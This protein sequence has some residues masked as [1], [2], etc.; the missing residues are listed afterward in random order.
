MVSIEAFRKLALA[1][2][3]TSEDTH[4]DKI[5]FRVKKKIFGTYDATNKQACLKLSLV[6][7]DLF[8]LIYKGIIYPVPN[9]WGRQGWTFVR[10]NKIKAEVFREILRSAYCHVAPQKLSKNYMLNDTIF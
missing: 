7:Q 1:Y 3:E 6:D 5:S 9:T 2:P 8:S 4:F 10:L